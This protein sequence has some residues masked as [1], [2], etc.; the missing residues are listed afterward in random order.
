MKMRLL[1]IS[2]FAVLALLLARCG[3]DEGICIGTTGKTIIQQRQSAPFHYIEVYDNINLILTQDSTSDGIKVE[4][5]ENLADGI[6]TDVEKGRLVIRNQNSCNWFRSFEVPIN[7]YL[8]FSKLDSIIF[9]A[10]G[11]IS[12]TNTWKNEIIYLDVVEGSGKITLDINV[13]KSFINVRY[14]TVTLDIGGFSQVTYISSQGYGPVHAED[15]FSKFTYVYTFSPND[16]FVHAQSELG[17][18]IKNIGNVYYKGDPGNI[19]TIISGEGKLI[20]F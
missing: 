11:N 6:T 4:A 9:R 19:Y 8:T 14:G 18:E 15:V 13:F 12:S 1:T 2:I 5:G 16:V 7:V 3:N 20:E 17:V 10:A